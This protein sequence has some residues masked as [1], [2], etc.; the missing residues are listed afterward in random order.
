MNKKDSEK[1]ISFLNEK[2]KGRSCPMCNVG[3]WSV[4]DNV[5]ELREFQGGG[6][7]IGGT[8]IIPIIPITCGN[9]GNTIFVNAI[10]AGIVKSER[11]EKND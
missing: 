10:T 8:P 4:Q 11:E 2:W 6:L 7:V 3:K 9:C 5:F 1:L